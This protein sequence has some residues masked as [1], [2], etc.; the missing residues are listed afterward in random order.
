MRELFENMA[1]DFVDSQFYEK[2]KKMVRWLRPFSFINIIF[3]FFCLFCLAFFA[4]FLVR[5]FINAEGDHYVGFVALLAAMATLTTLIYNLRRHMSEDYFKDAKEYLKRAFETFEPK[6]G[7]E[8]P[9]ND[10][11]TWLTAA[12]LIGIAER[13]GNK[14]IMDSHKESFL[15]E[16]EYWRS[17]FRN[18]IKDFAWSYY[19]DGVEK[20]NS[21][22][23][24]DREPIAESSIYAI[25]K[26]IEWNED[27]T[28]PLPDITF[29]NDELKN[30]RRKFP[31]LSQLLSQ[32]NRN[33]K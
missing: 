14:I 2:F 12:R 1:D 26:F 18:L 23:I 6:N 17:K 20:F 31:S 5:L 28:D 27:Y 3:Y 8:A 24:F 33:R 11:M 22:N 16:K 10:R 7:Q 19:C 4:F 15:E 25:H 32:V 13:L 29:S 30:L 9:P 21:W